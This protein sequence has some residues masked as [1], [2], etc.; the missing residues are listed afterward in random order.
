MGEWE[1]LRAITIGAAKICRVDQRLGSLAVGKDADLVIYNGNPLE[2]SSSVHATI[3]DGNV[4]WARE[5][6]SQL[7][8]YKK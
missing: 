1:A 8:D 6:C 7:K 2:V 3:I 5:E 4:V